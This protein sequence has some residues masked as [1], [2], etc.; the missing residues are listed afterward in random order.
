[1][2]GFLFEADSLETQ[3]GVIFQ[4]KS[5]GRKKLM[6]WFKGS[7]AGGILSHSEAQSQLFCSIQTFSGL[8]EGHPH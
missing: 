8:G 6:S 5:K 4:F 3:S 1:M 7:Q 2:A